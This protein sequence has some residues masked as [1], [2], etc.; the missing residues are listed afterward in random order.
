MVSKEQWEEPCGQR[1]WHHRDLQLLRVLA[2]HPTW[3]YRMEVYAEG[4]PELGL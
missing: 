4:T 1:R 3:T 2:L